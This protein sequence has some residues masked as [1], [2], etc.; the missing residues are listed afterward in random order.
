MRCKWHFSSP[1]QLYHLSETNHNGETF[2][3]RPMDRDRVMDGENWRK[4]RICVSNS[5]DGSISSLVDSISCP[6]GMKLWVHIPLDLMNL[7]KSNKVYRPSTRQ[8]PD[9]EVTGEHWLKAPAKFKT[10]GQIEVLGAD[11]N[12]DLRYMWMGE[13]TKMDRFFWKWLI[14]M[15]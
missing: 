13:E 11:P 1:F 14:K 8:V 4:P 5:I 10:I 2:Y 12:S 15:A 3:P 7:F 6:Y 9:A